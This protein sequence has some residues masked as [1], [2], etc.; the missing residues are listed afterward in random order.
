MEEQLFVGYD[1]LD[2]KPITFADALRF[3]QNWKDN[4]PVSKITH[5]TFSLQEINDHI[6][7]LRMAGGKPTYLRIYNGIN[8]NGDHTLIIVTAE[9]GG[10]NGVIES[11]PLTVNYGVDFG[12]LCPPSGNCN[13]AKDDKSIAAKIK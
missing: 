1:T 12:T 3:A 9:D 6:A 5:V 7:Q 8:D 2:R 11:K 13:L 4:A 10:A